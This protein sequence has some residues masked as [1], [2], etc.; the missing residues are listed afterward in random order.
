MNR[1]RKLVR[2]GLRIYSSTYSLIVYVNSNT[3]RNNTRKTCNM[4]DMLC[5]NKISI[6]ISLDIDV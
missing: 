3:N 4:S 2:I 1:L 6:Q 5:N